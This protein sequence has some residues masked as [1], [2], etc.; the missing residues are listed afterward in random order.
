M[1]TTVETVAYLWSSMML[2]TLMEDH[3]LL[4][5][6]SCCIVVKETVSYCYHCP[7]LF[8]IVHTQ[9]TWCIWVECCF[10]LFVYSWKFNADSFY[11]VPQSSALCLNQN[12]M[13]RCQFWD[14][15]IKRR[16]F[17]LKACMLCFLQVQTLLQQMQDKFQTMSDQIIGR[18]ILPFWFSA[19]ETVYLRKKFAS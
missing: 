18:N 10:G 9:P 5:L 4:C 14:K 6:R 16:A 1:F 17:V 15:Q 8:F 13:Y 2:F 11:I 7:R 3:H 12:W 19:K